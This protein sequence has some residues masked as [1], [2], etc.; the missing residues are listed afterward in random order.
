MFTNLISI[1]LL[2]RL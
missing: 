1:M 2:M